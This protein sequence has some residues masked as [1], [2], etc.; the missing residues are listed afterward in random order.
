MVKPSDLSLSQIPCMNTLSQT[1]IFSFHSLVGCKLNETFT[2]E[3]SNLALG[4]QCKSLL[5][6]NR[7]L[8][9]TFRRYFILFWTFKLNSNDRKT[10]TKEF[11]LITHWNSFQNVNSHL[12]LYKFSISY[13]KHCQNLYL[14][15]DFPAKY[16]FLERY[17]SVIPYRFLKQYYC[18]Q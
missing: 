16:I 10:L 8:A 14:K 5:Y 18:L 12:C 13:R 3:L 17:H 1:L 7:N 11:T 6:R 15:L 4:Q 2:A 9:Q